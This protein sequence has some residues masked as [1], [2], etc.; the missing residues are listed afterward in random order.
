PAGAVSDDDL[1]RLEQS[2][3]ADIASLAQTPPLP[4]H[5]ISVRKDFAPALVDRL[6]KVLLAMHEN[7]QGQRILKKTDDTTKFDRLPEGEAGLRRRLEIGRASGR[8]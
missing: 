1:A 3:R 2:Q 8:E 7:E 6:E 4:R 5:F